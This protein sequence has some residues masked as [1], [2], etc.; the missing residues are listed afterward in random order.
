MEPLSS[1]GP[2]TGPAASGGGVSA[3]RFVKHLADSGLL[4]KSE[5]K[6]LV[7]TIPEP[8]RHDAN[9]LAQ[10]L[11]R[12]EKLTRYQATMLSQG[13]SKGLVLGNYVVLD[14]LGAGGMGL[15]F[16]ARHRNIDRVVALKV[17]PPAVTKSPGAVQRFQREVLAAAKLSHP[18]IVH[19]SDA[20]EA[21]GV[22]FLVM[23][24]VE[25]SD[26]GRRVKEQ[27]PLPVG[28]AIDCVLQAARG[29]EHAHAAGIVHRDI[30]PA[31][32]LL[33]RKGVVKILDMGLARLDDPQAGNA[34]GSGVT[35]GLTQTGSILGTCDYMSPEQAL[36]T[37]RADHR[38]DVYSLGGTLYFLLTGQ[39]QYPGDT[40][41]EK[42]IAHREMPIPSLR[43]LRRDVTPE[44]DAVYQRMVAK[45][46]DDRHQSMR[47]VIADLEACPRSGAG[48]GGAFTPALRSSGPTLLRSRQADTDTDIGSATMKHPRRRRP[49]SSPL[50]WVLGGSVVAVLVALAAFFALRS[51]AK[52]QAAAEASGATRSAPPATLRTVKDVDDAW[53]K[54]VARRPAKEQVAAVWKRL[55]EM[56]PEFDGKLDWQGIEDDAVTGLIISATRLENLAPLRA[57]PRLRKLTIMGTWHK[58]SQLRDLA[59]LQSLPLT[60]LTCEFN[61]VADL[62]PLRKMPLRVLNLRGTKVSDLT[63]IQELPL[64]QLGIAETPVN[65]L[66]PLRNMP[67]TG[68]S[69]WG[70]PI[71]DLAALKG[72]KLGRLE[73]QGTK[74]FD[75]TPLQA[76]PLQELR[77]DFIPERDGEA[78]RAIATLRKINEQDAGPIWKKQDED[79]AAFEK[80]AATLAGLPADRLRDA[81]VAELKR[82]N[83]GFDGTVAAGYDGKVLTELRFATDDVTDLTPLRALKDLRVVHCVGSGSGKGKLVSL[84]PLKDL[85]LQQMVIWKNPIKDLGP[86][87]KMPLEDLNC[88]ST[89]VDD[90]SP[91][92]GVPLKALRCRDTPVRDL[93]PL[94]DK[95]LTVLWCSGDRVA[96]L[97]VLKSLPVEELRCNFNPRRDLELLRSITTLRV[98]NEMPADDFWRKHPRKP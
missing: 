37:H 88:E 81:V 57:L 10:E 71:T 50:P 6:T 79:R 61:Q 12:L 74:V 9:G 83:P 17:L 92:Q 60:E 48:P 20:D 82:R 73:C 59:P 67:L 72:T 15:V 94:K 4:S 14:R 3:E 62:A 8:Q 84:W 86:L 19:A 30:K 96:D 87:R 24:Y 65:D 32:L 38:S 64:E 89:L 36:N 39:N 51:S 77:C 33:D 66:S 41:M 98:I 27:G 55:E 54:S 28:L 69:C 13:R 56:N 7:A 22:H 58:R 23:D 49:A 25:G 90:L 91:L 63:P 43:A 85:R 95:K 26:L 47:E 45:K 1:T 5:I 76:L 35:E 21:Q 97:A 70:C 80:W 16:K 31:N 29:L 40:A 93:G 75:F 78:L 42:L 46:V 52:R 18:N 11:V 68:L 34:P 53:I 2:P 44:L